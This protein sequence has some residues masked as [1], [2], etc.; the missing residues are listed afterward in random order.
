M[1]WWHGKHFFISDSE[2]GLPSLSNCAYPQPPVAA[3]FFVSF[4]M[5]WRYQGGC[6]PGTN[7]CSRPK[8]LLFSSE[9]TL[10]HAMRAM[11]VPSGNG[12]VPSRIGLDRGIVT[13]NGSTIVKLARF[14]R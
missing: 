2:P 13:Q 1:A 6:S 9:G 10:R 7:D 8:I 3:Y 14:V 4:T 5:N 12:S 11:I